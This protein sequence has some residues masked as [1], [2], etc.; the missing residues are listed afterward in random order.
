M[1]SI[2]IYGSEA[3]QTT[4][5]VSDRDLL[6]V[7]SGDEDIASLA[8]PWKST[9]WNVSS[10][11]YDAF[12][13]LAAR[14]SLFVQHIKQEATIVSDSD[15]RLSKILNAFHPK[16]SYMGE[17]NDSIKHLQCLPS[18]SNMYWHDLCLLDASY[19]FL[20]N[21]LILHMASRGH[22]VF[23]YAEILE[24]AQTEFELKSDQ[25][26]VLRELRA[27]KS[28]YRSR[29]SFSNVLKISREMAVIRR[30]IFHELDNK[31]KS[32]VNDGI[33]SN[34]YIKLRL[35]ELS[36]VSN[37][38]PRQL[39]LLTPTDPRYAVWNRITSSDGYPKNTFRG[40][41]SVVCGTLH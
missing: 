26:D 18:P 34:D 27:A 9:G 10:F 8:E 12:Q 38:S 4:D 23:D 22:F 31:D 35:T 21:A 19:V 5:L 7:A 2:C 36:L 13:R 33:T 30:T 32:A 41:P 11:N 40:D 37:Y 39:D 24:L 15:D 29:G 17:R 1:A 28:A 3:R 20:R 14:G 6:I 25:I 16:S